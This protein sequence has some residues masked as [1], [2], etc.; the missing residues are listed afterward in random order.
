MGEKDIAG[1][2][3]VFKKSS[4]AAGTIEKQVQAIHDKI[5]DI[6]KKRVGGQQ[7]KVDSVTKIIDEV[8]QKKTK[9]TVAIKT[10]ERNKKKAQEKVESVEKEIEENNKIISNIE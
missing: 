6:G 9:A 4:E 10:S 1:F 3:K 2:E 7:A 5:M 8:N